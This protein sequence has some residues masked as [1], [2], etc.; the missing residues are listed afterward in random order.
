MH[1]QYSNYGITKIPLA[2]LI[3]KNENM[4]GGGGWFDL[5][6]RAGKVLLTSAFK[7]SR[8]NISEQFKGSQDSM[9]QD[10]K[11][12]KDI[13]ENYQ[14]WDE[15]QQQWGDDEE[16]KEEDVDQASDNLVDSETEAVEENSGKSRN[17]KSKNK[18]KESSL[19]ELINKWQAVVTGEEPV[20]KK[21]IDKEA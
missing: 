2:K 16:V 1:D 9:M 19:S 21:V 8:S 10:T 11:G 20:E 6:E 17:R 14:G 18:Y 12:D 5:D 13:M 3:A 15:N 7:K 4:T